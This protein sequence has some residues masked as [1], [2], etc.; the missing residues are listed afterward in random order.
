MDFWKEENLREC[1]VSELTMPGS[2]PK[3]MKDVRAQMQRVPHT[4]A[5]Q[6]RGNRSPDL[7]KLPASKEEPVPCEGTTV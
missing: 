5:G 6:V 1:R 3:R 2:F 7:V 4:Q